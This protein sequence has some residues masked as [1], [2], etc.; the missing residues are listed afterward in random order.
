MLRSRKTFRN[1]EQL[2]FSRRAGR[3]AMGDAAVMGELLVIGA[4][5]GLSD[6]GPAG[7][8]GRRAQ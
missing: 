8:D 5:S 7:P 4:R 6:R 1:G 3:D 2:D